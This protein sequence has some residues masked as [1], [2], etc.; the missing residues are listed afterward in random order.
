MFSQSDHRFGVARSFIVRNNKDV[1]FNNSH[2]NWLTQPI[3]R[4]MY[5]IVV[6]LDLDFAAMHGIQGL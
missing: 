2:F 1:R 5:V 6:L 3:H 4:K